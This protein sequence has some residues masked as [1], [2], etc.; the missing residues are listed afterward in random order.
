[1]VQ[2]GYMK[3]DYTQYFVNPKCRKSSPLINR[4]TFARTFAIDT[5]ARQFLASTVKEGAQILSL[6]S[7]D[8]TLYWRLKASGLFASGGFFEVDFDETVRRKRMIIE[9]VDA[10]K[11]E[12]NEKTYRLIA[13]DLCDLESLKARLCKA[14]LRPDRP[15]L[16]LAECVLMYM[17]PKDSSAIISWTASFFT[18]GAAFATYEPFRPDD[19]YGQ[20]MLKNFQKRGC[21]LKSM[22]AFPTLASQRSRYVDR[23][24]T[25]VRVADMNDVF[26]KYLAQEDVRRILRLEMFDEFEEWRLIQ[27]HYCLVLALLKN[28]ST[29]ADGVS[30]LVI[31]FMRLDKF[32]SSS[33]KTTRKG[34]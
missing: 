9:N 28:S 4:G 6:G 2:K 16:I 17:P 14:G 11:T 22:E 33:E 7:G 29:E 10:L 5:I 32:A 24:W 21:S 19:K 13:A 25:H 8:D 26:N 30:D 23:K 3:D 31:P 27:G 34:G 1:M 15:T 20:M 12:T 18:R